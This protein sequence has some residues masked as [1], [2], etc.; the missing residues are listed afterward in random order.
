M[1]KSGFEGSLL[2]LCRNEE[3]LSFKQENFH[4]LQVLQMLSAIIFTTGF[5]EI[6]TVMQYQWELSVMEI[7]ME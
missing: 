6:R 5:M 3:P 7:L 4:L 2:I 1:I